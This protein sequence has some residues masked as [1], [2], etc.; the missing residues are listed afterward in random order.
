MGFFSNLFAPNSV[1]LHD[2]VPFQSVTVEKKKKRYGGD[3]KEN[4]DVNVQK[5]RKKKG[6]WFNNNKRKKNKGKAAQKNK[7]KDVTVS[8]TAPKLS[9]FLQQ[10]SEP[11]NE[12]LNHTIDTGSLT[13]SLTSHSKA[14]ENLPQHAEYVRAL[15]PLEKTRRPTRPSSAAGVAP[16]SLDKAFPIQG[17][18]EDDDESDSSSE[19]NEIKQPLQSSVSD[20][21]SDTEKSDTTAETTEDL[22][23]SPTPKDRKSLSSNSISV[24][25][26]E[27]PEVK[28]M[29][30]PP[31]SY[32]DETAEL[33]DP[34]ASLD[35]S[36]VSS[37][38]ASSV[39]AI[40]ALN[41]L[42][43]DLTAE[44]E[45]FAKVEPVEESLADSISLAETLPEVEPLLA[46]EGEESITDSISLVDSEDAVDFFGIDEGDSA[47]ADLL[48]LDLEESS[49]NIADLL[50]PLKIEFDVKTIER[51]FYSTMDS[52][53]TIDDDTFGNDSANADLGWNPSSNDESKDRSVS[54]TALFEF[55]MEIF[56]KDRSIDVKTDEVNVDVVEETKKTVDNDDVVKKTFDQII[57]E[58]EETIANSQKMYNNN[59][60]NWIPNGLMTT[61]RDDSSLKSQS[62]AISFNSDDFKEEDSVVPHKN[63]MKPGLGISTIT[64]ETEDDGSEDPLDVAIERGRSRSQEE[65]QQQQQPEESNEEDAN[66]RT[67]A[68]KTLQQSL[69]IALDPSPKKEPSP[70][71]EDTA[72]PESSPLEM[73]GPK[74][75]PSSS[76][77]P[78]VSTPLPSAM[79]KATLH[80][81]LPTLSA[82]PL[83]S[84][85]LCKSMPRPTL[86]K[87]V[88]WRE[89]NDVF[90][91]LPAQAEDLQ[92]ARDLVA[93]YEKLMSAL[94]ARRP[95]SSDSSKSSLTNNDDE[96]SHS[97]S[98]DADLSL[99]SSSSTSSL[100]SLLSALSNASSASSESMKIVIQQL[101]E[102]TEKLVSQQFESKEDEKKEARNEMLENKWPETVETTNNSSSSFESLLSALSQAS[103]NSS[104]SVKMVVQKL[105]EEA[106]RRVEFSSQRLEEE[107]LRIL[108]E[109]GLD[110]S[111]ISSSTFSSSP[112]V[113][114]STGSTGTSESVKK[115]MKEL[116]SERSKQAQV[117]TSTADMFTLLHN[118]KSSEQARVQILDN[119]WVDGMDGLECGSSSSLPSLLSASPCS[120]QS[121]NDSSESVQYMMRALQ[122]ETER[123]RQR[124]NK[125]RSVREFVDSVCNVSST[126]HLLLSNSSISKI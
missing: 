95:A 53:N 54:P 112:S 88:S 26:N 107:K 46:A 33:S 106:E 44:L 10:N 48:M 92:K 104:S 11:D 41:K 119:N 93:T 123:Q 118:K 8:T 114:S 87:S 55:D 105:K 60:S 34:A 69:T 49:T 78:V 122:R 94:N 124:R 97:S 99:A 13:A 96:K 18:T 7:G 82:N 85:L 14:S 32:Y 12:S 9:I 25:R 15:T 89:D 51:D 59:S 71:N 65:Q 40:E 73:T 109:K 61:V 91:Y 57:N 20:P 56:K 16:P 111:S 103:S 115:L 98:S 22:D 58:V 76:S 52:E 31:R 80:S 108:K 1:A 110:D 2:P 50:E 47:N 37:S 38:D 24:R 117:F 75:T 19:T 63:S 64:E 113:P 68:I 116:N 4:I 72:K 86:T 101:T 3:G 120:S 70:P 42:T 29:D 27:I 125:I 17:V 5:D 6:G 45:T 83:K 74:S 30:M 67:K 81:S 66:E 28:L 121:S 62:S 90:T 79:R 39:G 126:S 21:P 77:P 43:A 35:D 23:L 102:E 36:D 84:A 100:E